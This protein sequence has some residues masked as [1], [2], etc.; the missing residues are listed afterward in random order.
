MHH[1]QSVNALKLISF[2]S[3]LQKFVML[4]LGSFPLC[5]F[6]GHDCS[7]KTYLAIVI[8]PQQLTLRKPTGKVVLDA[9]FVLLGHLV[10]KNKIMMEKHFTI[11]VLFCVD[12]YQNLS[13]SESDYR[14][15]SDKTSQNLL[16]Q[17][18]D[19]VRSF[20][21]FNLGSRICNFLFPHFCSQNI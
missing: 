16:L 5:A 9:S 20:I 7:C 11:Y 6:F 12:F 21:F 17:N 1:S 3:F 10:D 4:F 19:N 14:S 8:L 15:S 13:Q 18:G 2:I